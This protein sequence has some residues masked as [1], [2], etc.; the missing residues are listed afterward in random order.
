M[1]KITAAIA[2][3]LL[4][5]QHSPAQQAPTQITIIGSPHRETAGLTKAGLYDAIKKNKPDLI[6]IELDSSMVG[7]DFTMAASLLRYFEPGVVD[8]FIRNYPATLLRPFDIE[9]RNAFFIKTRFFDEEYK[10][11]TTLNRLYKNDSLTAENK[12]VYEAS[13]RFGALADSFTESSLQYL[14][15]SQADAAVSNK[16]NWYY[17]YYPQLVRSTPALKQFEDHLKTDSSFWINRNRA[18]A[19]HIIDFS[20]RFAGKHIVIITGFFHRYFL[21]QLLIPLETQYGFKIKEL[22]EE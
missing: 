13:L 9:G 21:R 17:T 18:M 3:F 8:S 5:M 16:M 10:M 14:N 6:L 2:I 20:K 22:Y 12:I 15:S 19:N 1:L 4:T 11:F 7:K